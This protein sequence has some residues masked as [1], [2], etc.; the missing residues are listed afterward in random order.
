MDAQLAGRL[1]PGGPLVFISGNSL[2][3]F[4][5]KTF[6]PT[7]VLALHRELFQESHA[8]QFIRKMN[9][10]QLHDI[11]IRFS[12]DK[13]SPLHNQTEAQLQ[14]ILIVL[15]SSE[16]IK[17]YQLTN[18]RYR[19]WFGNIDNF[20]IRDQNMIDTIIHRKTSD[21]EQSRYDLQVE[22]NKILGARWSEKIRMDDIYWSEPWYTRA[23][24][25]TGKTML[26]VYEGIEGLF[27]LGAMIIEATGDVINFQ[28]KLAGHMADGEFEKAKKQL[29]DQGIKIANSVE[30]MKTQ[31]EEGYA[32]IEPIMNDPESRDIVMDYLSQYV[33]S[34]PI[35]DKGAAALTI[36]FDVLLA[37]VTAGAGAAVAGSQ[38]VRHAGQFTGKA[39][40]LLVGLSKALTKV[41]L[42]K[43]VP[44]KKKSIGGVSNN[45]IARP[46]TGKN[47]HKGFH[48]EGWDEVKVPRDGE[49]GAFKTVSNFN[50][51]HPA[52]FQKQAMRDLYKL[53][54]S[55]K[56][57]LQV[58][59]SGSNFKTKYFNKGDKVYSFGT[60]GRFKSGDDLAS[61]Y[62]LDEDQFNEVK[63]LH[64]K[65][66]HWN[67]EGVKEYLA[68]PCFNRVDTLY[69][70]T[71]KEAHVG[72]QSEIG[73]ATENI[74]YRRG[75]EIIQ[76]NKSMFGGGP[77]TS[78]NLNK[79]SGIAVLW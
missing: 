7:F 30:E 34:M 63:Q 48:N 54:Y 39:I 57:I 38:V 14:K 18:S 29:E 45:T 44:S 21:I 49:P 42:N 71:V 67:K 8:T 4:A 35:V 61:K 66:G 47:P 55:E 70:S 27:K 24:I 51:D 69:S 59:R 62:M 22:L 2:Y 72:V 25:V 15:I 40:E 31:I 60:K 1:Q 26:N 20:I 32:I 58:I 41:K 36:P 28:L 9:Y 6:K 76:K 16:R 17:V 12:P 13:I 77:Q 10:R 23:L 79:M 11:L 73:L 74:T 65:D 68:L 52:I 19:N 37:L 46:S 56:E 78:L 5:G 75:N 50:K 53:G 43:K 64:F 3:V 33:D